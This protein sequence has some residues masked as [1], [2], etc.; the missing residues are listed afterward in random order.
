[1]LVGG[2]AGGDLFTQLAAQLLEGVDLF[3]SHLGEFVVQFGQF[4][5]L[6]RSGGDGD[7]GVG[8]RVLATGEGAGGSSRFPFA[9]PGDRLVHAFEHVPR[10]D[11]VGDAGDGVDLFLADLGR[12]VDREHVTLLGRAVNRDERSETCAQ[13]LHGGVDVLV[14]DLDVVHRN[15]EGR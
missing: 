3:G 10:A 8:A 6:H 7:L 11:L 14:G 15:G 13:V 1:R 2:F 12:H 5:L 9:P 4:A